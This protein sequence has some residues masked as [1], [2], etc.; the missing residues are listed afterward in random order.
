MAPKTRNNSK[1][2]KEQEMFANCTTDGSQHQFNKRLRK[3]ENLTLTLRF[4]EFLKK[5]R[6]HFPLVFLA[7]LYSERKDVVF[8]DEFLALFAT[9]YLCGCQFSTYG[10]DRWCGET[11]CCVT[12]RP[13]FTRY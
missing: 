3:E 10:V 5:S 9:M 11:V 4:D 1:I 7:Q 6:S 2:T 13:F 8:E 12:H